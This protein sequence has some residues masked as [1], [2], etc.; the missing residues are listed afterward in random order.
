MVGFL[1]NFA[2]NILNEVA[3]SSDL[4]GIA[5][6]QLELSTSI[7]ATFL[8]LTI[9]FT[10]CYLG[11]MIT[12]KCSEMTNIAYN[13]LWYQFPADMQKYITPMIQYSQKRIEFN[14]FKI[15]CCSLETFTKVFYLFYVIFIL[16]KLKTEAMFGYYTEYFL[17]FSL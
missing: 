2:E 17:F 10:M 11:S 12:F 16:F 13:T 8:M 14:G 3:F 9:M 7:L 6:L 4:K 15:V 5:N 1:F